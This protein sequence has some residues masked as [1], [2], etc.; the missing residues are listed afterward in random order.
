MASSDP[1]RNGA[2]QCGRNAFLSVWTCATCRAQDTDRAQ[3][4]N[5]VVIAVSSCRPVVP[6][7]IMAEIAALTCILSSMISSL[8]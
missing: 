7:R 8:S 4:G 1:K 2:G 5:A 3:V 6:R